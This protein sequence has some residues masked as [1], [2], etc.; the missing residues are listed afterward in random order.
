MMFHHYFCLSQLEHFGRIQE[1]PMK[2]KILSLSVSV[3]FI[4]LA[5]LGPVA[6]AKTVTSSVTSTVTD[7]A[8]KSVT[9]TD[10]ATLSVTTTQTNILTTTQPITTT[11]SITTTAYNF[12]P[13]VVDTVNKEVSFY[14]TVKK[15]EAVN[16]DPTQL[17][18]G[19]AALISENAGTALTVAAMSADGGV[20]AEKLNNALILIGGVDG[21][22]VH[23]GD[24]G[25]TAT[26]TSF[27]V[28]LVINGQRKLLDD[29]LKSSMPAAKVNYVLLGTVADQWQLGCGCLI[30]GRSG[31]GTVMANAGYT[32][33]EAFAGG[34][35]FYDGLVKAG[36]KIGDK[37]QVV[38]KL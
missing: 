31:P 23:V 38:I 35:T 36:L 6:C 20:N 19:P 29:I 32:N 21:N 7:T 10:T 26:G 33:S 11:Q 17:S 2:N 5:V 9:T 25:K 37:V 3:L 27:K 4:G 8:I 14:A 12:A 15:T 13:I 18:T 1:V 30:C 24:T 28:Y 22:N 16:Q 34:A